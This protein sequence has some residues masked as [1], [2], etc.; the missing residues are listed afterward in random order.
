MI[1]AKRVFKMMRL[2]DAEEAIIKNSAY[3]K[4]I[5]RNAVRG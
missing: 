4:G 5:E 2:V 3:T 1:D